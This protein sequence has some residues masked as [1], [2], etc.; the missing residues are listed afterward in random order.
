MRASGGSAG[1]DAVLANHL[2]LRERKR[3]SGVRP[4]RLV[5][6]SADPVV[7]PDIVDGD[8]DMVDAGAVG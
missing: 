3:R 1:R 7:D 5:C 2:R 4:L 8:I 6:G